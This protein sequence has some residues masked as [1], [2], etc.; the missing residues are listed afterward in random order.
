MN[1]FFTGK[2]LKYVSL[3]NSLRLN[4]LFSYC[5]QETNGN[6]VSSNKLTKHIQ[7]VNHHTHDSG[8]ATISIHIKKQRF[9]PVTRANMAHDSLGQVLFEKRW[10][11]SLV[12]T[13][14]ISKWHFRTATPTTL[15]EVNNPGSRS[16]NAVF[17]DFRRLMKS[18]GTLTMAP[19]ELPQW[20]EATT[21][22][23]LHQH[24]WGE[25]YNPF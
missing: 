6:L 18:A 3:I 10:Q 17:G 11:C 7:N 22:E 14:A 1:L 2:A 20:D 25:D 23:R 15:P 13:K 16:R 8:R 19:G 21:C 24:G 5:L 9:H 4:L 12:L